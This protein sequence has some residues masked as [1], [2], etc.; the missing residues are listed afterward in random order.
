MLYLFKLRAPPFDVPSTSTITS[1]SRIATTH[2]AEVLTIVSVRDTHCR[3]THVLLAAQQVPMSVNVAS[4]VNTLVRSHHS[5]SLETTS[6]PLRLTLLLDMTP[7]I[8]VGVL[9]ASISAT[10]S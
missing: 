6:P 2:F 5:A 1:K 4:H 3:R 9:V 10:S 7:M 8:D